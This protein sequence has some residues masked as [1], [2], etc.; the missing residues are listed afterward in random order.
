MLTDRGIE[1]TYKTKHTMRYLLENAKI[2][3]E[4]FENL[5][6]FREKYYGQRRRDINTRYGEHLSI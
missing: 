2:K 1:I 4:G 6:E 3:N 5:N